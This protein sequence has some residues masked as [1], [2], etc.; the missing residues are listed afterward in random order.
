M[1]Y[2]F[3]HIVYAAVSGSMK[4]ALFTPSVSRIITLLLLYYPSS[5]LLLSLV[6]FLVPSCKK[7]YRMLLMAS[8]TTPLSL[9]T[10]VLYRLQT[11]NHKSYSII[12]SFIC[13]IR[14]YSFQLPFLGFKSLSILPDTSTAITISIPFV[15]VL[16]LISTVLG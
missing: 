1:V 14:R 3:Y 6:P 15:F 16:L 5:G 2:T 12:R 9:V 13:K 10:G 11:H 8:S 4:P 7:H